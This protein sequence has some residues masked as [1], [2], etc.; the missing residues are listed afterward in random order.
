MSAATRL[1]A[2]LRGARYLWFLKMD[3][4]TWACMYAHPDE[5]AARNDDY[6]ETVGETID[7][8]AE[9]M[10]AWLRDEAP[11][12]IKRWIDGRFTETG[13]EA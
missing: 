2:R 1:P 10:E 9:K 3:D 8:A 5:F 11:D 6:P 12:H 13:A 7:E 4:G